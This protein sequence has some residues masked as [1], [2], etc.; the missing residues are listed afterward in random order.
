VKVAEQDD[1]IFL[2]LRKCQSQLL[3]ISAQSVRMLRKLMASLQKRR[4]EQD[5]EGRLRAID[6]EIMEHFRKRRSTARPSRTSSLALPP[7]SKK[8]REMLEALLAE[9]SNIMNQLSP[10]DHCPFGPP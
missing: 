5:A 1:E 2:E 4:V 6:C 3:T 10:V 8:E 7:P 9:R